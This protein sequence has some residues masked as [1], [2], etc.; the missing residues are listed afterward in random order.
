MSSVGSFGKAWLVTS[1]A[2]KKQYCMKE[3]HLIEPSVLA[4]ARK[5]VEI[6]SQ[7]QHAYIIQYVMCLLGVACC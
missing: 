7:L 3:M 2:D 4:D 5:E 1:K 6:L